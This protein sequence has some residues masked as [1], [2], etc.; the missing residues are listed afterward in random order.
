MDHRSPGAELFAAA[1]IDYDG[2]AER[3]PRNA[4]IRKA[5]KVTKESSRVK[6]LAKTVAKLKASKRSRKH[7]LPGSMIDTP[8]PSSAKSNR[9]L[10]DL[11]AFRRLRASALDAIPDMPKDGRLSCREAWE[12]RRALAKV[13]ELKTKIKKKLATNPKKN[14]KNKQHWDGVWRCSSFER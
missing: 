12:V 7:V 3:K 11:K 6:S 1:L 9:S 2:D 4:I 13:Q 10:R 5:E 14:N 8:N